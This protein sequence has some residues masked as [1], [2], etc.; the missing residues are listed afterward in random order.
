MIVTR[1]GLLA[2]S[3]MVG[4]GTAAARAAA[5]PSWPEV[6]R[7]ARGETV[8]WNAWGGDDSTN[9][10]IAWSGERMRVLHDVTVHHVRL[11]DTSEAVARVV[12]ERAAGRDDGGSVDLIW[13]NGPNFLAMKEQ[14]LLY[15]PV[16]DALPHAGL[17]DRSG[18]P[19]TLTDFTVP[20]EGLEV[21][22]RMARVV[23]VYD[24]ARLR[25]PPGSMADMLDWSVAHPGRLTHPTVGNFLGATFLKQALVELASD[26]SALQIPATDASFASVT[27]PLWRWYTAL[28]PSL[29]RGGKIFPESGPATIRLMND[30][31][32]D[33]M[34]SFNPNE[35]ANGIAQGTLPGTVRAYVLREGTIG[36]C[37]FVAIPY[38]AA[39]KPAA[40][41][42]ADFL[43]TPEAQ[44]RAMDPTL[45][46]SP[47]VLALDRLSPEDQRFFTDLPRPVGS[48]TDDELGPPLAEP[49]PSWMTRIA[50]AWERLAVQ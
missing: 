20:T 8:F 11:R 1:R 21:P 44:A 45:L 41:L 5:V 36:N 39:H 19:T 10:F 29:W 37:S 30:G 43:L 40:L 7:T 25:M 16:L 33:L 34:I 18:K 26:R 6:E 24:S 23:F 28:R 35:A 46:G 3:A 15:G 50:A 12:A 31:E 22:W 17:I 47:T 38:N 49:H 4:L 32:I 14:R 13:I 2:A 27:A 9:A 48:L 42:L